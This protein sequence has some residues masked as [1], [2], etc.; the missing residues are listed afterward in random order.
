MHCREV[1]SEL[2]A[3]G[4]FADLL[5]KEQ[6]HWQQHLAPLMAR[7]TQNEARLQQLMT[8]HAQQQQQ[9]VMLQD[10]LLQ[11]TDKQLSGAASFSSSSSSSSVTV[12][13]LVPAAAAAT[14]GSTAAGSAM[15]MQ[16][17]SKL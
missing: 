2:S 13:D 5:A 11:Q 3:P 14:V 1:L 17:A 9:Q 7:Y 12:M 10:V 16:T 15:A 8:A 6:Q 4:R